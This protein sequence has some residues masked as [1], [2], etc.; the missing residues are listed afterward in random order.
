MKY[1]NNPDFVDQIS[2]ELQQ[3]KG[4]DAHA[5]RAQRAPG[6]SVSPLLV[7]GTLKRQE[8]K[9]LDLSPWAP[10]PMALYQGGAECQGM[11]WTPDALYED[12][13]EWK[14]TQKWFS[15]GRVETS[16]HLGSS[17]KKK[18][19]NSLD[20][21]QQAPAEKSSEEREF[22]FIQSIRRSRKMLREKLYELE[23]DHMITA[24]K[25]GKF[26]SLDAGWKVWKKFNEA[27]TEYAKRNGRVWKAVAVPELHSDG[28]TW[29]FHIGVHG[30]WPH[31]VLWFQWQKALGGKGNERKTE[32]L[33]SIRIDYIKVKRSRA[34][35]RAS[36]ASRIA[37]YLG[38]YLGKGFG[39]GNSG[40]RLFASSRGLAPYR[41]ERWRCN[42]RE[43][44]PELAFALLGRLAASGSSCRA[45]VKRWERISVEGALLRCGFFFSTEWEGVR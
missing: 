14:I 22:R 44:I 17:Q 11:N 26:D 39:S 24:G 18:Q 10:L 7:K 37:S 9:D 28:I 12:A 23:A 5:G 16:A 42:H 33:G 8:I 43:G 45:K 3:S 41:V 6:A 13:A 27:M 2:R 1:F 34:S 35:S 31:T 19:A 30:F 29:H 20:G 32:S 15:C 38:K 21:S 25:R 36:V 4:A 40:R